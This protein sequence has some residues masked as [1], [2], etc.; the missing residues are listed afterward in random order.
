MK[1]EEEMMFERCGRFSDVVWEKKGLCIDCGGSGEVEVV[2]DN[3][4]QLRRNPKYSE[5]SMKEPQGANRQ[6]Q[7][8]D[9]FTNLRRSDLM[10]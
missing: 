4:T 8:S 1:E 7:V 3:P 9:D 10:A 2:V 5:E 6:V